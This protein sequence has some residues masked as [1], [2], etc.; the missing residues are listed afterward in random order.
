M[1]CTSRAPL[2]VEK[3]LTTPGGW[4]RYAN[5]NISLQYEFTLLGLE[6]FPVVTN[7]VIGD[8]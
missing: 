6:R 2:K 4:P 3:K 7:K 8:E 5:Q 1:G